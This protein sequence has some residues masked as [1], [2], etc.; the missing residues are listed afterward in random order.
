MGSQDRLDTCS[1]SMAPRGQGIMGPRRAEPLARQYIL[2]IR[3]SGKL[4]VPSV[5]GERERDT[6]CEEEAS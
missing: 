4:F 2:R 5:H 1:F 3:S 6:E